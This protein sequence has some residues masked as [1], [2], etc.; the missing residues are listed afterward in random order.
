MRATKAHSPVPHDLHHITQISC[1]TASPHPQEFCIVRD[2]ASP[3]ILFQRRRGS[4]V[5]ETGERLLQL[6]HES[7]IAGEFLAE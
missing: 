3:H 5:V 4:L 2:Y 6:L 7:L 1:R